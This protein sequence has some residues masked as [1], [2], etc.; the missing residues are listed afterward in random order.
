MYTVQKQ[1]QFPSIDI[2]EASMC[3]NVSCYSSVISESQNPFLNTNNDMLLSV[4][5]V[6]M[7]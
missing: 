7:L 3:C 2:K 5:K 1:M 4:C 6:N